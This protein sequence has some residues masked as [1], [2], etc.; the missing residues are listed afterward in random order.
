MKEERQLGN[1]KLDNLENF[2][3]NK[4]PKTI[5]ISHLQRIHDQ[6][7][8]IFSSLEGGNNK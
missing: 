7:K 2:S 6:S 4:N 1:S 8:Q 3:E 5:N